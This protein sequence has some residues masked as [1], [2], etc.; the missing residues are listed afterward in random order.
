MKFMLL[1]YSWIV[2]D[3]P[4]FNLGK[5]FSSRG[6][7]TIAIGIGRKEDLP[8]EIV[9]EDFKIVRVSSRNFQLYNKPYIYWMRYA[10]QVFKAAGKYKPDFYIPTNWNS[11]L[12]S[13][14][15]KEFYKKPIVYYQMEYNDRRK[16]L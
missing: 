13:V 11:F 5:L 8:V 12:A 15:A 7:K 9:N 10:T 4:I 14:I 6:H 2:F 16:Q 1:S 3:P